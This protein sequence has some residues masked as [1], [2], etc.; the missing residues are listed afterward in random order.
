MVI[1]GHRGA[2]VDR[3]VILKQYREEFVFTFVMQSPPNCGQKSQND[4]ITIIIIINK[5]V[6]TGCTVVTLLLRPPYYSGHF[7]IVPR[8]TLI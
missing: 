7:E 2:C 3:C 8:L 5:G 6:K 1:L 4:H